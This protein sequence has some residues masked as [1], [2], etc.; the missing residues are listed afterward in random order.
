MTSDVEYTLK[1]TTCG[2]TWEN[3]DDRPVDECV[4]GSLATFPVEALDD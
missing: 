4:C 1:C 3:T 2:R